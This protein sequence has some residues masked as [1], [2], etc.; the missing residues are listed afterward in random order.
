MKASLF[1]LPLAVAILME[2]LVRV[3]KMH[4]SFSEELAEKIVHTEEK[5]RSPRDPG[6]P[7]ADA[8]TDYRYE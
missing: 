8:V 3:M 5:E 1:C 2:V 6:K 7:G 4:V